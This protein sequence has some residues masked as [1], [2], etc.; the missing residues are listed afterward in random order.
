MTETIQ[1]TDV[2]KLEFICE[3][4]AYVCFL[5]DREGHLARANVNHENIKSFDIK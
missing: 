2:K 4:L 1:K 5:E 3:R